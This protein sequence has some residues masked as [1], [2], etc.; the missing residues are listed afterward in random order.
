ML[1]YSPYSKK[2]PRYKGVCIYRPFVYG[3]IA[4]P[5]S[6]PRPANTPPDH[7]HRWTIFVRPVSPPHDITH[8]LRKVQFKLHETYSQSLR[9]I[10]A[11]PFEVTETGWGEFEVA[12]K[13]FFVPEASE[14]PISIYHQLKLHPYGGTEEDREKT[15]REGG[16]VSSKC[17]EEVCFNEPVEGLWEIL[18]AGGGDGRGNEKGRGKGKGAK[19]I[20]SVD[21]SAEIPN[22]GIPYS[23][24]TEGRELDRLK[25]AVKQVE[26]MIG[27]ERKTLAEREK[28]LGELRREAAAAE[29]R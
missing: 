7:T 26:S 15:R 29:K 24:R 2:P 23:L 1:S 5:L 9:T 11:P 13:L 22:E 6:T 18:T 25:E 27:E 28:V 20:K 17:Y 21:R 4:I 14:K 3:S 12:I 8:W 19:A 10:E 16:E